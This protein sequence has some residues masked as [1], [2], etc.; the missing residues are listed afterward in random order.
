MAHQR[1]AKT[2]EVGTIQDH[3]GWV[4]HMDD[5]T[6]EAFSFDLPTTQGFI[7]ALQ[8]AVEQLEN[9]YQAAA[10]RDR[11]GIQEQATLRLVDPEG[12]A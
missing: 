1:I 10:F 5:G 4:L 8:A 2:I 7:T 12:G 3:I 6:S 9:Q 11:I